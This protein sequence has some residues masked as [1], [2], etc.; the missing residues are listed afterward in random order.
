[1]LCCA[2]PFTPKICSFLWEDLD[3]DLIRGSLGLRNLPPQRLTDRVSLFSEFVVI[4]DGQTNRLTER[5]QTRPVRIGYLR[6]MSDV[7]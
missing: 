5:T 1:M 7:A 2:A 4:T 3:P 6:Y